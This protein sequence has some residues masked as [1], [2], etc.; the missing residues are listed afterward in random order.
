MEF[1]KSWS[2]FSRNDIDTVSN[3]MESALRDQGFLY[4]SFR[5]DHF[6]GSCNIINTL[7]P[8]DLKI[9]IS[10]RYIPGFSHDVST[11]LIKP[12][13]EKTEHHIKNIINDFVNKCP[14]KPWEFERGGIKDIMNYLKR[15]NLKTIIF[16]FILILV[17]FSIFLLSKE[18]F[19]SFF[20]VSLMLFAL[21][22]PLLSISGRK[23]EKA[24]ER[25]L[26]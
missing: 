12:V 21:F 17:I 6:F 26:E 23:G 5:E 9:K 1:D 20:D 10:D 2:A 14:K 15:K 19:F 4:R 24:W 13:I 7:S 22:S 25:W 8:F 18:G 3:I 11:I 16:S